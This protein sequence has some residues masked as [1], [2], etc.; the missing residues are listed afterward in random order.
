MDA[1]DY[2][3]ACEKFAESQR[4]DPG[5]GT[6]LNLAL[7]HELSGKTAS[8]WAEFDQALRIARADG[9]ADREEFAKTHLSELA[10]RLS[11][12]RVVVPIEARVSGLVVERNGVELG[13]AA[14]D[15]AIAVDPGEQIV[16]ARAPG[17]VTARVVVTVG[18]EGDS[19]SATIPVLENAPAVEPAPTPP[20][21]VSPRPL[22]RPRPE[23]TQ[24]DADDTPWRIAG[25][26]VG[27]VGLVAIGVGAYFGIRALDLQ[28]ESEAKC[29]TYESCHPDGIVAYEDAAVSAHASTGLI[30]GGAALA[31]AGVFLFF[32]PF[33]GSSS[34]N[35][36]G[37][38]A[39]GFF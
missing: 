39:R 37:V 28:A 8:A 13:E 20:P 38:G 36:V 7:C 32:Y 4:L 24:P 10:P 27:A 11:R 1:K 22:V 16:E 2:E 5:G 25:G 17:K 23:P 15:S 19:Q 33:S 12:L 34:S 30:I 26:V 3:R 6:L 18:P 14:W 29:P 9:R 31:G 21:V 35:V